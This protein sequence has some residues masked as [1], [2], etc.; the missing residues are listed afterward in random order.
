M[1]RPF[2]HCDQMHK[3][4]SDASDQGSRAMYSLLRRGRKLGLPKDIMF[5][6]FDKIITPIL[7]YGCEVWGM[8][9]YEKHRHCSKKNL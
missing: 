1:E 6:L 9:W 7:L 2:Q 3:D 5:D 8:L 4:A